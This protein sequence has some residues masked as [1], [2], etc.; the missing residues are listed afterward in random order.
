MGVL[1]W[2]RVE[3]GHMEL[4]PV[5]YGKYRYIFDKFTAKHRRCMLYQLVNLI[6]TSQLYQ[7]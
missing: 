4:S 3:Q 5:H 7:E 2:T 6:K 1:V